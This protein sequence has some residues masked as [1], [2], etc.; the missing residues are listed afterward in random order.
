[1]S[2]GFLNTPRQFEKFDIHENNIQIF[3]ILAFTLRQRHKC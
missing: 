1:M 2:D 3:Q